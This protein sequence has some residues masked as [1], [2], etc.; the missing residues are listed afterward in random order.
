MNELNIDTSTI[1]YVL[2]ILHAASLP[3]HYRLRAPDYNVMC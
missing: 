2:C 1:I 3:L